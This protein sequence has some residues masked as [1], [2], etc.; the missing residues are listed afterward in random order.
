M[1]VS[2]CKRQH[3]EI[4]D[5]QQLEQATLLIC[6]VNNI[7]GPKQPR[8]SGHRRPRAKIQANNHV[9]ILLIRLLIRFNTKASIPRE[10][11]NKR[12]T[13]EGLR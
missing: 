10:L 2:G 13:A 5:S 7:F 8:F 3:S 11:Y 12:K 9:L 1:L 4:V 6:S